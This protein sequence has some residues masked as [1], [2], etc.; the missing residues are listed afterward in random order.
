[1]NIPLLRLLLRLIERGIGL[2]S[3]LVANHTPYD[4]SLVAVVV[5]ILVAVLVATFGKNYYSKSEKYFI[6]FKNI[7]NNVRELWGLMFFKQDF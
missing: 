5:A 4:H 2:S 3:V 1:M 6:L 7:L